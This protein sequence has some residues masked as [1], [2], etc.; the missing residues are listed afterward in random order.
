LFGR[1]YRSLTSGRH[2]PPAY[3]PK[4]AQFRGTVT[5]NSVHVGFEPSENGKVATYFARWAGRR[6]DVGPWSLPVFM[7]IAA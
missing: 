6:G 1:V 3:D 5:R 7:R 4:Q 2:G